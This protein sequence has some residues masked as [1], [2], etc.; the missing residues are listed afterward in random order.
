MKKYVEKIKRITDSLLKISD[1]DTIDKKY[2]LFIVN[3]LLNINIDIL[4]NVDGDVD[5]KWIDIA[6]PPLKDG[7]YLIC[8]KKKSVCTA[9]FYTSMN[10]FSSRINDS[11]VAW[12]PLPKPL[13]T[14]DNRKEYV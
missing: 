4:N 2:I 8:T 14:I 7:S 9:R 13:S 12:M 5:D 6:T 10:K 1:N 11:V 3:Q